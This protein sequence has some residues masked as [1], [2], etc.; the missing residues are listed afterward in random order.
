MA[1]EADAFWRWFVANEQRFRVGRCGE[2]E[3]DELLARLHEHC[4][5]LYLELG[6]APEGPTEL[7]IT[8]AGD[9]ALFSAVR[10]LVG[11]APALHGWRFIAFKPAQGFDF[12]TEYGAATVEPRAC[13]FLP[14]SSRA[15]LAELGVRVG[16]PGYAEA[17][18]DDFGNAVMIVLDTVLGELVAAESLQHVEVGSLPRDP[19]GEGYLAL[20]ELPAYLRWKAAQRPS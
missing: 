12:V 2:A 9:R 4:G 14:M 13:W 5:G 18:H 6:G 10:A 8:A 7:I 17:Q 11:C 16:C 19:E 1:L 20:T 3:L 15:N